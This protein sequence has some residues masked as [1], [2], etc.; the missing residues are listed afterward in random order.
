[1]INA[2]RDRE[3]VG[4]QGLGMKERQ[5]GWK[6]PLPP[7]PGL[8]HPPVAWFDLGFP[9]KVKGYRLFYALNR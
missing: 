5:A 6:A 4:E 8:Y 7:L 9:P 3:I 1:M 2:E